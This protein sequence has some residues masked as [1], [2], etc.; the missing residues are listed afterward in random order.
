MS[1]WIKRYHLPKSLDEDKSTILVEGDKRK[2]LKQSQDVASRV[3]VVCRGMFY[4]LGL[5]LQVLFGYG[6]IHKIGNVKVITFVVLESTE[7]VFKI[8]NNIITVK[9][10]N[11]WF[12]VGDFRQTPDGSVVEVDGFLIVVKKIGKWLAKTTPDIPSKYLK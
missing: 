11:T 9:Q 5:H 1:T 7:T 4:C 3:H 6:E 10:N 8:N 12:I 2:E